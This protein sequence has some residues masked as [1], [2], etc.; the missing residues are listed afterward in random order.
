MN[1]PKTDDNDRTHKNC[2]NGANTLSS[3]MVNGLFQKKTKQERGLKIYFSEPP[4]PPGIFRFVTLPLEVTEK[5]S[6]HSR[7][8][9]KIVWQP[10]EI[11]R[12]KTK[13]HG[14]FI[15]AFLEHSW[16]FHFY[17]NWCFFLDKCLIWYAQ[18]KSLVLWNLEDPVVV[19]TLSCRMKITYHPLLTTDWLFFIN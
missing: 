8:F 11:P 17:F 15:W 2:K 13:T 19:Q 3:H 7:K 18:F 1:L 16:S 9:C 5:T 14:N 12:S 10:L 4:P 6:F